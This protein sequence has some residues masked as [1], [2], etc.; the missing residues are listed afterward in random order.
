MLVRAMSKLTRPLQRPL[1]IVDD[2][3]SYGMWLQLEF[4]KRRFACDL[5]ASVED[6]DALAQAFDQSYAGAIIDKELGDRDG[7]ALIT[8]L[9]QHTASP[10]LLLTADESKATRDKA[11]SAGATQVYAKPAD[12]AVLLKVFGSDAKTQ[13]CAYAREEE[14][15]KKAFRQRLIEELSGV[16]V[17][18]ERSEL[19][20]ALHRLSGTSALFG[21][22][23]VSRALKSIERQLGDRLIGMDCAAVALQKIARQA[24]A[25]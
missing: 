13:T 8:R 12:P 18:S 17:Q 19:I 15:L 11:R 24:K 2:C 6:V 22:G 1:L 20:S 25:L 10:L 23:A 5:F 3:A 7:I 9:R 14:E 21:Y 16:T 4:E